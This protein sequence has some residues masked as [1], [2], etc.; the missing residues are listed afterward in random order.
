MINYESI[1]QFNA[2]NGEGLVWADPDQVPGIS[3][4]IE[5]KL[6]DELKE[7]DA[8]ATVDPDAME[9]LLD[10][11]EFD[12][13]LDVGITIVGAGRAAEAY[14]QGKQYLADDPDALGYAM[15]W[16]IEPAEHEEESD[17]DDEADD[18]APIVEFFVVIDPSRYNP[19]GGGM[20]D[21]GVQRQL[22]INHYLLTQMLLVA[23][24]GE[25]FNVP[26]SDHQPEYID[27][28]ETKAE[29]LLNEIVDAAASVPV[30]IA[31]P[32]VFEGDE[33]QEEGE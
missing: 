28:A 8:L 20:S 15:S 33:A 3:I 31:A 26:A 30:V 2:D 13:G 4:A 24:A 18:L 6:L 14:P 16:A 1:S 17:D 7:R 27:E 19:A 29:K 12:E 5:E 25:G 21:E 9:M 22:E 32:H 10:R 23:G 11:V